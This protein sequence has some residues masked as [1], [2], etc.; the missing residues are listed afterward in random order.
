MSPCLSSPA[1]E[2]IKTEQDVDDYVESLKQYYRRL[3]EQHQQQLKK[4]VR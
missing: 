3:D 4:K 1:F 2:R